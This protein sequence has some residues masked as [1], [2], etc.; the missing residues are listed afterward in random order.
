M[1]RNRPFVLSIAGFDPSGGAGVIADVKTFEQLQV[2]GMAIITANTLQTEDAIF[3]LEWQPLEIIIESIKTLVKRYEFK[4]V[5]I[6]IVPNMNY[7]KEIINTIKSCNSKTFIILDPVIKSSSGFSIFNKNDIG[8]LSEVLNQVDLTTP[9]YDEYLLLKEQI[10]F[11]K[12]TILVK[13]GHRNDLKGVD[14]L[15]ENGNEIHIH[16][17]REKKYNKHGSGCVLSSA[18]AAWVALGEPLEDACRSGK[19]YVEQYL[20]S[21]PTLLGYHN[22]VQ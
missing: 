21:Y 22:Y 10:Q 20:N 6:G 14:I 16:P 1:Q 7:L 15:Y 2:Q 3:K 17:I 13:G 18:I 5:K 4:A 8:K 19:N 11:N 9:N 12:T